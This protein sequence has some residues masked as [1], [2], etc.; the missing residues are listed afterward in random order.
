MNIWYYS[1]INGV[2]PNVVKSIV[3]VESNY[4]PHVTGSVGEMGLMQLKPFYLPGPLSLYDPETNIA[5]GTRE[6]SK[7]QRLKPRLGDQWYAAWNLGPTGALKYARK[8]DI[9]KFAYVRKVESV[10]L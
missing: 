1:M 2:D 6:L 9:K 5:V 3:E 4:R 10:R 8:W 7:L